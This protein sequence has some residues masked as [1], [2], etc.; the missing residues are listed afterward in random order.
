MSCWSESLDTIFAER[1]EISDIIA[2]GASESLKQYL[3]ADRG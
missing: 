2:L 3:S 1:T